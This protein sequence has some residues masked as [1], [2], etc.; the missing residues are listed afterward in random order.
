MDVNA[1]RDRIIEISHDEAA[2]D[3]D[4]RSKALRWLNSAYHEIMEEVMPW[5]GNQIRVEEQLT[6]NSTGQAMLSSVPYRM[7]RVV[8][9]TNSTTLQQLNREDVL[10]KDP[11]ETKTGNAQA[12]WQEGLLLQTYP[13]AAS[14]ALTVLYLPETL[15]LEADG[16]EA[17][18]LLPRQFHHALV[19]GG[20]VW[21]ATYERG[22]ATQAEL[23]LFQKKWEEAKRNLKLALANQPSGQRRTQPYNLL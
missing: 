20:L 15:D 19:W 17:S 9:V 14:A 10:D 11:A 23:A 2:P 22:F 4:L 5:L 8:D 18:I 6:T 13:K 7:V 21:S 1:L 12:F 16:T 3:T